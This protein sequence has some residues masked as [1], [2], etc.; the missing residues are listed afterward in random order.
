[1]SRFTHQPIENT[2]TS[3]EGYVGKVFRTAKGVRVSVDPHPQLTEA[4][5]RM[6][7]QRMMDWYFYTIEHK[8]K[9]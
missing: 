9:P 7:E 2:I 4:K 5:K 1:M 3:R 6:L 8:Q